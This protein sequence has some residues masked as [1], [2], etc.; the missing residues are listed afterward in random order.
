MNFQ[1]FLNTAEWQRLPTQV[2]CQT[3]FNLG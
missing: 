1:N 3:C 2:T